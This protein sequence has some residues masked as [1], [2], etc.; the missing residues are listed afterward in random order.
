MHWSSC[1]YI[2]RGERG[3]TIKETGHELEKEQEGLEGGKRRGSNN[4]IIF[5]SQI[6]K[7]EPPKPPQTVTPTRETKCWTSWVYGGTFSLKPLHPPLSPFTVSRHVD[8]LHPLTACLP[9]ESLHPVSFQASSSFWSTLETHSVI[10]N[11]SFS[12]MPSKPWSRELGG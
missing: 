8:G 3:G 1:I 12:G 10:S 5:W 2:F 9:F 4:V 6:K 11:L 7:N